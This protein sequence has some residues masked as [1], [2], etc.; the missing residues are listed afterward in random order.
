MALEPELFTRRVG[1]FSS[2]AMIIIGI[3]GI[4]GWITGD[5]L[6]F[7]MPNLTPIAPV[8]A[9]AYVLL[10][11]IVLTLIIPLKGK[12]AKLTVKFLISFIMVIACMFWITEA[13]FPSFDIEKF[14]VTPLIGSNS[15]IENPIAP[16]AAFAI[17]LGT[18]ALTGIT[19]MKK[20]W[21][22][23]DTAIGI[24]GITIF[25]IG[26]MS[27]IGYAFGTPQ[28][29]GASVKAVSISSSFALV[30][31]GMGIIVLNGTSKYPSSVFSS[32]T[33]SAQMNRILVPIIIV[34]FLSF[35]WVLFRVIIPSSNDP[36][37]A[38]AVFT[39]ISIA[40]VA[41]TVSF[42]SGKIQKIIENA[43]N[44]KT[45]AIESL[46]LANKK[47][48]ILD[49]LT[50]HDILNQASLASI[51]AELMKRM[52]NEPSIKESAERIENINKTIIRQLQFSKEY[53]KVGIEEPQWR[54]LRRLLSEAID[55]LNFGKI[56]VENHCEGWR[57]YADPMIEKTFFNILENSLRHGGS[58]TKVLI[59]CAVSEKDDTLRIVLSDNGIGVPEDEKER[60]FEKGFGKNTGLGLFLTRQILSITGI[61]IIEN[62]IPGKGARF[63]ISIP[64][65]SFKQG[66]QSDPM[67]RA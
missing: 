27:L 25:S 42:V 54:N 43:R 16:L 22:Y 24:L 1:I 26:F 57:I 20:K 62:G 36:V 58:V 7:D 10:G 33:V 9:I 13:F 18:V 63:E 53:R 40:S 46:A 61:S 59:E 23:F 41:Y 65:D 44:E 39:A 2:V 48:D 31:F 5:Y 6:T 45:K 29:Y 35:S 8:A 32:N 11:S 30:F 28:F 67:Q 37:P 60:I 3:I 14:F 49:S 19:Y 4:Y 64:K 52:S 34:A 56:S 17:F 50:R 21:R 47:L 66:E 12:Y 38:V 51:E 15:P 55:Q